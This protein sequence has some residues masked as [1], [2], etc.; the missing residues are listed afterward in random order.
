MKLKKFSNEEFLAFIKYVKSQILFA[1]N[2]I[3]TLCKQNRNIILYINI[4]SS[5]LLY[6]INLELNDKCK[7][8]IINGEVDSSK[9]E[10]IE[11][12]VYKN[13]IIDENYE[14]EI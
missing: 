1:D 3:V 7:I 6:N 10:L 13:L 8:S 2:V 12:Y 4:I 9:I 11:E 14:I 5:D